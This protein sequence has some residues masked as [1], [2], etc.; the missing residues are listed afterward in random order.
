MSTSGSHA[1]MDPR[2]SVEIP[3]LG[4][5]MQIRRERAALRERLARLESERG[6]VSEEVLARVRADYQEK[7]DDLELRAND[8]SERARRE[9]RSLA[10]AVERQQ[11]TV[12]KQRMALE[13]YDLR[14]RLGEV[15][16]AISAKRAGE[17]RHDL[18]RLEDDLRAMVEMRDRV[19][20]I[21]DSRADRPVTI[22]ALATT[23]PPPSGALPP[24]PPMPPPLATPP[25]QAANVAKPLAARLVPTESRDGSDAFRL[26]DRTL[27]GRNRESDLCL[28]VGTVSRRHAMVEQTDAG[29][30]VRDLHSENGTWVNGERVWER[31]LAEGDQIQFGTVGLVFHDR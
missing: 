16:D 27:V 22:P 1:R 10:S 9:A 31:T 26:R 24:L 8:L 20:T 15:L 30:V 14:E 29:W 12:D 28:P 7:A 3:F 13:E 21:A 19:T 2:E 6:R 17:M 18:E 11:Q 23:L 25:P 5:W 4:E